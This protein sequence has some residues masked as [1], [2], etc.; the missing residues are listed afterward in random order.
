MVVTGIS[1]GRVDENTAWPFDECV[2][3]KRERGRRELD[4]G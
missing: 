1:D 3:I 4:L 2:V